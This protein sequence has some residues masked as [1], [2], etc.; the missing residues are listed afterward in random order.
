M[1]QTSAFI[2]NFAHVRRRQ[3][4]ICSGVGLAEFWRTVKCVARAFEM[5]GM[6]VA[7]V[8]RL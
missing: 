7:V 3:V 6:M 5:I 4:T 2:S 1:R 8:A